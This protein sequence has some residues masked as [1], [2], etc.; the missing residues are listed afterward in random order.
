MQQQRLVL[1]TQS[2]RGAHRPKAFWVVSARDAR[3]RAHERTGVWMSGRRQD[4]GASRAETSAGRQNA[5]KHEDAP[6]I[7]CASKCTHR[8]TLTF[9][10]RVQN[11]LHPAPL[12][13]L[14]LA[15]RNQS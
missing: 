15:R 13:T 5:G 7:I 3:M 14:V 10:Q 1:D 2:T 11:S 4:S 12:P 6:C 8:P 9:R